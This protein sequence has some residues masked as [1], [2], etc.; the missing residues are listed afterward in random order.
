METLQQ[1]DNFYGIIIDSAE[2]G[3]NLLGWVR[4]VDQTSST[5]PV[6]VKF[7]FKNKTGKE[8]KYI[9]FGIRPYNAVGDPV[10][11]TIRGVS[12]YNCQCTGPFAPNGKF[13]QILENGWYNTTIASVKI[14]SAEI[15]YMDD[16]TE[17]LSSEQ[18]RFSAKD[19][20]LSDNDS[21]LARS[22]MGLLLMIVAGI[23][24]VI[25][26]IGVVTMDS[27]VFSVLTT[28]STIAFI[29]GLKMK[30]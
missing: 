13:V 30:S 4:G 1:Q 26:I 18:I 10:E 5:T 21:R 15:T 19:T 11:C 24:D 2:V 23:I 3:T 27:G 8:I 28:I 25:S 20:I 17:T 16:S 22:G 14:E 7:T 12:L 29:I 6:S 9:T